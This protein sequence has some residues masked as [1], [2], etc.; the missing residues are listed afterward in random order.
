MKNTCVKHLECPAHCK[1]STSVPFI[2]LSHYFKKFSYVFFLI[3][4]SNSRKV[5]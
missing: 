1:C 2:I 3:P 4:E 5:M